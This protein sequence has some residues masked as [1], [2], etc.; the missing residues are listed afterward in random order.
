ML[1]MFCML[2]QEKQ[3]H[4]KLAEICFWQH[5]SI[6][7]FWYDKNVVQPNRDTKVTIFLKKCN[8]LHFFLLKNIN[9]PLPTACKRLYAQRKRNHHL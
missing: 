3:G 1:I 8:R 9:L 7:I 2:L 4:K 6:V 5:C